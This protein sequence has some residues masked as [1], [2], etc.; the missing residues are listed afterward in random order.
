MSFGTEIISPKLCKQNDI[1]LGMATRFKSISLGWSRHF[2]FE[3]AGTAR[4][5]LTGLKWQR[6]DTNG[7]LLSL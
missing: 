3:I 2:V 6:P 7:Q 4:T 5:D 1:A